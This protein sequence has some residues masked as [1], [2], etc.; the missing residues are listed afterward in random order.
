[1]LDDELNN[2]AHSLDVSLGPLDVHEPQR[3]RRAVSIVEEQFLAAL[4]VSL[5]KNRD[6]MITNHFEHF[7]VTVRIDGMICEPYFVA[8]SSCVN[9]MFWRGKRPG[10]VDKC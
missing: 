2:R 9:H 8:F 10:S 6:P 1:M 5:C 4:N 3:I 7:C